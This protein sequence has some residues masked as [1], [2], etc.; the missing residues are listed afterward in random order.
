MLF[1]G[2]SKAFKERHTMLSDMLP[3]WLTFTDVVGDQLVPVHALERVEEVDLSMMMCG[4]CII[5]QCICS[6]T[7]YTIFLYS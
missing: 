3:C 2:C 1:S 4:P 7:R 6:P 5:L